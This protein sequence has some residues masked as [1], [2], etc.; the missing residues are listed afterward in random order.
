MADEND[1]VVVGERFG[2]DEVRARED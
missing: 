1:A 2:V